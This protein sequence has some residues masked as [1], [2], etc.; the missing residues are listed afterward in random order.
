MLITI[1]PKMK[2]SG[3]LSLLYI[4]N[5]EQQQLRGDLYELEKMIKE[6]EF[7]E[8]EDSEESP[9]KERIIDG[10][11]VSE[12]VQKAIHDTVSKSAASLRS[13]EQR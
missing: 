4:I 6:T 13:Y 12:S 9:T 10:E 11:K 1:K 2:K 3:M 8:V 7:E 5:E